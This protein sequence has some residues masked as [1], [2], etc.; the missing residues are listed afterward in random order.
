MQGILKAQEKNM[1]ILRLLK[2]RLGEDLLY[3][4]VN[5]TEED[6][7]L[8]DP[9]TDDITASEGEKHQIKLET[10]GLGESKEDDKRKPQ[11]KSQLPQ[12]REPFKEH[13]F[14]E[15]DENDDLKNKSSP[16][17]KPAIIIDDDSYSGQ[18]KL[19][20]ED[21]A[22][23]RTLKAPSIAIE[24]KKTLADVIASY[25]NGLDSLQSKLGPSLTNTLLSM[26]NL[27]ISESEDSDHKMR[28]TPKTEWDKEATSKKEQG[29]VDDK[30]ND[31]KIDNKVTN[32]QEKTA[33]LVSVEETYPT[34]EL[35]A[36]DIMATSGKTLEEVIE[37]YE[38]RINEELN[39][40]EKEVSL[41]KEKLGKDLFYTLLPQPDIEGEPSQTEKIIDQQYPKE[42][43]PESFPV[44]KEI[45][46]ADDLKAK[47]LLRD[48]GNTVE[49]VL[50]K[51]EG[52]LEEL[53]KLVPNE[54]NAGISIFRPD[55]ELRRQ[56]GRFEKRKQGIC[57]PFKKPNRNHRTR[58]SKQVRKYGRGRQQGKRRGYR[59]R[60]ERWYKGG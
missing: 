40:L 45:S 10:A 57:G 50:R 18:R 26:E 15:A 11:Q 35:K 2:E 5:E 4:L 52:Q 51:Y 13:K 42:S 14:P 7:H 12:R 47:S 41:L 22:N 31:M 59:W 55:I 16:R 1:E 53:A 30:D 49:N 27:T 39:N 33:Q 60:W 23:K 43:E 44:V 54:T 46:A 28:E 56:A 21:L 20:E 32:A 38:E 29:N 58:S 19:S 37:D 34:K 48:D 36:P 17:T 6:R 9:T 25:E 3:A 8:D 24:N